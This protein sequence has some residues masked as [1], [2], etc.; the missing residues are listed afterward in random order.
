MVLRYTFFCLKHGEYWFIFIAQNLF[1]VGLIFIMSVFFFVFMVFS[2]YKGCYTYQKIL[3]CLVKI[4]FKEV[5][6][7]TYIAHILKTKL[8]CQRIFIRVS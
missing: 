1:I 3:T 5:T 6:C 2:N 8:D 7:S 4:L